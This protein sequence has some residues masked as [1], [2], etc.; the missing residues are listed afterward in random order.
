LAD[1]LVFFDGTTHVYTVWGR[2][3]ASMA[4]RRIMERALAIAAIFVATA[5]TASAAQVTPGD[6]KAAGTD[7][8]RGALTGDIKIA[9][10][11]NDTTRM[12]VRGAYTYASGGKSSFSATARINGD[13]FTFAIDVKSR[14]IVDALGHIINNGPSTVVN[15]LTATYTINDDGTLTGHWTSSTDKN[16]GKDDTWTPAWLKV[17]SV[18]PKQFEA[19]THSLDV[20]IHGRDMPQPSDISTSDVAFTADGADDAKI[21][22]L[23]LGERADDGSTLKVTISVDKDAK[24]GSR[25]IRVKDAKADDVATVIPHADTFPLGSTKHFDVEVWKNLVIPL[26]N[27]KLKLTTTAGTIT[28]VDQNGIDFNGTDLSQGVDLKYAGKYAVK[29]TGAAGDVTNSYSISGETKPESKPYNFWYW[30]FDSDWT[31]AHLY[32]DGGVYERVDQVFGIKHSSSADAFDPQEHMDSGSNTKPEH[33][34]N[35]DKVP[36]KDHYVTDTTKGYAWCYQRSM[37]PDK[38][39]WGHCWGA[40]IAS[41]L[42]RHPQAQTVAA[43]DGKQVS[44]TEEEVKGILTAYYTDHNVNGDYAFSSCPAGRP[45]E[46]TGEP[47][48]AYADALWSGLNK[49]IKGK[50]LPMASNLRAEA[51]DDDSKSQVWNHVV[52]KFESELKQ[53]PKQDDPNY[54]EIAITVYATSDNYPSG[55]D[56]A[57]R[58]ETYV[59]RLR[60]LNGAVV[61]KAS[62]QNWVSA[63]HYAPS[64]LARF[65]SSWSGDAGC[66]NVV[67]GRKIGINKLVSTFHYQPVGTGN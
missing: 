29:L 64:Y 40:V 54:V 10:I 62:D 47:V 44:F 33:I 31:N 42:H 39:W 57:P 18:D 56:V 61:P 53:A 34:F 55:D 48:D 9:A 38:G 1:A 36:Q 4:H 26:P 22:V 23:S 2:E 37:D 5:G 46:K 19:D 30:P 7:N 67:L 59:I 11:P 15:T 25:G 17:E 32:I 27:G 3:K 51:T 13:Q 60:T 49:W 66:N 41:S 21:H 14:S 6:Y 28:L 8:Q 52:W 45:T 24:L 50:G 43:A 63:T 65:Q 20:T 16:Y 58:Q 35:F 12:S